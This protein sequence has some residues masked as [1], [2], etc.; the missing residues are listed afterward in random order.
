[1]SDAATT[2]V[3]V[4]AEG[5]TSADAA[6]E[7]AAEVIAA[8][9]TEQVETA[10]EAQV[11]IAA[12]EADRDVTIA[13]IQAASVE[14]QVVALNDQELQLCRNR[15]AEL[16]GENSTLRAELA[17]LSTP[18]P[19]TPQDLPPEPSPPL[20]SESVEA[21]PELPEV[22]AA[23]APPPAEPKRKKPGVRWI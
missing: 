16:E 12:I 14:A 9:E 19:S 17:E 11:E 10:A 4:P 8:A 21:T 2:V 20:A 1:M 15:I 3:V 13:A 7:V 23:E 6:P 18:Q 5:E 22:V